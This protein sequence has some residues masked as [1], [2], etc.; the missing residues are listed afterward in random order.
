MK[1]YLGIWMPS[2]ERELVDWMSRHSQMVDGKGTYQYP[3]LV[4]TLANCKSFRTCIDQGSHIGLWTAHLAKRFDRVIC[5]EPLAHLRECWAQNVTGEALSKC[6]LLPHALGDHAGT[7]AMSSNPTV[8]GDSWI[9]G[10]GE[11]ATGQPYTA[12]MRT[13]DSFEFTDVDLIKCDA[14]G[15]EEFILRGAEATITKWRPTIVVEQKRD[16]ACKFGLKP[17]GAIEFL[18]TLGYAEV[19]EMG[20]DHIMVHR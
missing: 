10:E 15:Y 7:I 6:E 3:K 14:E 8:C 11:A 5:F 16:M 13:L 9:K 18:K 1:Q 20:G 17:K 19:R 4:E 2:A 12:T